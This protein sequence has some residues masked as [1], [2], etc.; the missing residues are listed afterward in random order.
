M[1]I[2]CVW[3][4]NCLDL[5]KYG[6]QYKKFM[7]IMHSDLI[8]QTQSNQLMSILPEVIRK[9]Y[10][11]YLKTWEEMKTNQLPQVYSKSERNSGENRMKWSP[12][13]VQVVQIKETQSLLNW[14]CHNNLQN[15]K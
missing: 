1:I 8:N 5:I 13:W 15:F 12:E 4:N 14:I 7:N 11:S 6:T 9:T 2:I 3:N 10:V